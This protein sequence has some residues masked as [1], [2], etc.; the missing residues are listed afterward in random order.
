MADN[1]GAAQAQELL[2]AL[3][4]H[5]ADISHKL[6]TAERRGRP[7]SIR[8]ATHD[9]RLQN[10]LRQDLYEAHRLIDGLH[11]RFPDTLPASRREHGRPVPSAAH[12]H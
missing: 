12:I 5:V 4:E 6:E 3:H 11:R 8:G 10:S 2:G 7:A 9:R 1:A